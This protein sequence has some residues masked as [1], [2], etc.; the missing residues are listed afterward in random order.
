MSYV[1]FGVVSAG[2]Q[3]MSGAIGV[4]MARPAADPTS[5][6]L[7]SDVALC[8][9]D[10]CNLTEPG[11]GQV[12]VLSE[13]VMAFV[14]RVART[15]ALRYGR[16]V[17]V[18]DASASYSPTQPLSSN[19]PVVYQVD[20][21][22][23]I[24]G[25]LRP[26]SKPVSY[27]GYGLVPPMQDIS[28]FRAP[29]KNAIFGGL[30]GTLNPPDWRRYHRAQV[31]WPISGVG[32]GPS[33]RPVGHGHH[34]QTQRRVGGP[35]RPAGLVPG[36]L[37]FGAPV[38]CLAPKWEY[39]DIA[40][41]CICA[42]GYVPTPDGGDCI[43]V[44]GTPLNPEPNAGSDWLVDPNA[45]PMTAPAPAPAAACTGYQVG[46]TCVPKWAAWGGGALAA[47]LVL[48]LVL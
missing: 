21:P 31:P 12:F 28:H 37:G 35:P 16:A 20:A 14:K 44:T 19:G 6:V 38:T 24:V 2:A 10:W 39:N 13:P 45:G 17:V 32:A 30:G 3:T 1:G 42:P 18:R 5:V 34:S 47:L 23:P 4:S 33:A 11:Y 26:R 40:G 9:Q 7:E 41:G 25:A 8:D 48:D 43:P 46:S 15:T 27:H 29:Y 36:L 22:N